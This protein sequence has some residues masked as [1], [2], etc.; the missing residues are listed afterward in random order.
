MNC[1]ENGQ[2]AKKPRRFY[3]TVL[4]DE[5]MLRGRRSIAGTVGT[6]CA[7]RL[8]K[9]KFPATFETDPVRPSVDRKHAAHLTV[10]A[11]KNQSEYPK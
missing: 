7:S 6:N 3:E 10:A 1:A 9:I 5:T 2:I 11:P 8:N 4:E